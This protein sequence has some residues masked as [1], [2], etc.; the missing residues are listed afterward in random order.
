M[1]GFYWVYLCCDSLVSTELRIPKESGRFPAQ[2]YNMYWRDYE[3]CPN[4]GAEAPLI[5]GRKFI[6]ESYE[7]R[8]RI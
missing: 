7:S 5:E 2:D 3:G 8:Q 4:C 6:V 1:N